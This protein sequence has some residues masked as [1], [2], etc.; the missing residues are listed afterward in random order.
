[1]IDLCW[2][3]LILLGEVMRCEKKFTWKNI[4][5]NVLPDKTI[6]SARPVCCRRNTGEH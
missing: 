4:G 1:M 6:G 5:K 3:D 2:K